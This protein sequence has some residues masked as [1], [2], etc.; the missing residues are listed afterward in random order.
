MSV[1]KLLDGSRNEL[2]TSY[3]FKQSDGDYVDVLDAMRVIRNPD[4][5]VL[6]LVGAWINVA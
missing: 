5:E 3:R 6:E 2:N 1:S 4:G